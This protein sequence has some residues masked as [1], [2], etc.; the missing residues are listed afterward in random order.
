VPTQAHLLDAGHALMQEQ[1]DAMLTLLRK[2][3]A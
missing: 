2:A 1:P 3:L